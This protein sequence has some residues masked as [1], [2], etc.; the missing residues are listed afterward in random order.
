MPFRQKIPHIRARYTQHGVSVA[1]IDHG[2]V[3]VQV[4]PQ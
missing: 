1:L 3:V 2:R 4:G